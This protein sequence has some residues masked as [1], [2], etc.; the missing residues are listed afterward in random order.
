M[1]SV[2]LPAL[3]FLKGLYELQ[4]TAETSERI[5]NGLAELFH[6]EN[7]IL[8]RHDG[9][10]RILTA[11]VA[12]EPFSKANLMPR[13][14]ESGIMAMHPFWEGVFS[15]TEPVRAL[16][17]INSRKDWHANP[18]YNEVFRP[19]GIEDQLNTEVLG[20]A[21]D[22]TT[23][24]VLRSRRGFT[25]NEIRLMRI[26]REH[27][28]QALTNAR[29]MEDAGMT[30]TGP[31]AG[32]SLQVPLDHHGRPRFRD[33]PASD[34]LARLFPFRGRLPDTVRDWI[35]LGVRSLNEGWLQSKI[36]PLVFHCGYHQWEFLI[37]RDL[38]EGGYLLVMVP[39]PS[40]NGRQELSAREREVMG[41]VEKG[42]TNGEIAE[43]LSLSINTV[44]THLKRSFVK[45]GVENRT[46]AISAFRSRP[47]G[48]M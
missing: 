43:I 13:I 9:A 36:T 46:A 15:P 2:P 18:L 31:A 20:N 48:F 23:V 14:N 27:I 34:H 12:K 6:A 40:S 38:V 1:N 33:T 39:G 37:H 8:C 16:S 32:R 30:G 44:K 4:S 11:V 7:A 3:R 42:K 24:N 28:S 29:R 5:V 19:D 35:K 25:P 47:H 26:L 41:W 21:R 45:L 22:F 17:G 10:S